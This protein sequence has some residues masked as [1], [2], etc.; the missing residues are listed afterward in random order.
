VGSE[1]RLMSPV[2]PRRAPGR[3]PPFSFWT[4]PYRSDIVQ[5]GSALGRERVKRRRPLMDDRMHYLSGAAQ[6]IGST[7]EET[8]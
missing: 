6:N 4:R 1:A 5:V 7:G 3:K 2:P 8:S